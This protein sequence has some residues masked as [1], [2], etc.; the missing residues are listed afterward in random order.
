MRRVLTGLALTVVTSILLAVPTAAASP[1]SEA[2]ARARALRS[3]LQATTAELEAA[4]ARLYAAEEQLAFDQRQLQA[5]H[6]QFTQA[7]AAL[8]G[9]A[10]AMYRSGGLA[11]ADAFLRRDPNWSQ[12]VSSWRPS[13]LLARARR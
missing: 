10:A 4:E 1:L 13:W 9:Q 6:R 2:S 7:Q 8:A 3:Q 5:V 12:N 11:M